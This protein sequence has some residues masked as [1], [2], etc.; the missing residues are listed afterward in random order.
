MRITLTTSLRWFFGP[1]FAHPPHKLNASELARQMCPPCP[2]CI[3]RRRKILYRSVSL[4]RARRG[5]WY[6]LNRTARGTRRFCPV[7]SRRQLNAS[8]FAGVKPH[9]QRLRELVTRYEIVFR[10]SVQVRSNRKGS[11]GANEPR[12]RHLHRPQ[13]Y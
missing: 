2:T 4:K 13:L 10:T 5:A 1:T 9:R 8:Q 12:M 11:L 3:P 7:K 6:L